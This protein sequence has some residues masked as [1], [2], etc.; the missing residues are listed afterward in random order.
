MYTEHGEE[1]NDARWLH[2]IEPLRLSS[3]ANECA[4]VSFQ[5]TC[6]LYYV[7]RKNRRPRSVNNARLEVKERMVQ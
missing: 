1:P 2:S 3:T 4:R 7:K 5:H 6:V